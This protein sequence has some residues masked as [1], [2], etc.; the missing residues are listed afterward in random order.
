MLF[1]SGLR[2]SLSV[3]ILADFQDL[4]ALDGIKDFLED[5]VVP[6]YAGYGDISRDTAVTKILSS[7]LF[8]PDALYPAPCRPRRY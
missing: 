4:F 5:F 8:A 3:R 2:L 7:P 1:R 6:L